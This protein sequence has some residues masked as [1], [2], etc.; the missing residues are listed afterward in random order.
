MSAKEY[1]LQI[2]VLD[3][4]INHKQKQLDELKILA[5]CTGGMSNDGDRVQ[6]SKR[7]DRMSEAV[8]KYVDLE[9]EIDRE[10]DQYIALKG[11][12][13]SQ[14][15]DLEA[16]ENTKLYIEILTMR[17]VEFKRLEEIAVATGYSYDRIR[18][19]HGYALSAFGKQFLAP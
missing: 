5:T 9:R 7:G 2:G 6:T 11:K 3:S 13:I 16:G 17:Y 14:I 10:I 1:L 18:H 15:Y 8:A 12:V 19:L 4:K